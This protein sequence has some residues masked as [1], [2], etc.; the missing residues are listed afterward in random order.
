MEARKMSDKEIYDLISKTLDENKDDL[1]GFLQNLVR[2]NSVT[3]G[4]EDRYEKISD[5]VKTEME[6][7]GLRVICKE[8]NVIGEYGPPDATPVFIF[9]GH[10]DTVELGDDWTVSKPLSGEIINNRIYGRGA[11]DNKSGIAHSMYAVKILKELEEN[12]KIKLNGKIMATATNEE[13]LGGAPVEWL[14][15][16]KII[17]ASAENACILGDGLSYNQVI[18]PCGIVNGC[19]YG[20]ISVTGRSCHADW[21]QYGDNAI[22]AMNKIINLLHK[23]Q[24]EKYNKIKTKYLAH[25]GDDRDHPYINIG[26]IEGGLRFNIVPSDCYAMITI[27]TIPEQNI[28]QV[29][30]EIEGEIMN[31]AKKENLSV[32]F[33]IFEIKMPVIYDEKTYEKLISSVNRATGYMYG[34]VKDI[35]RMAGASDINHFV[36]AGIPSILMGA[37]SP[38]DFIHGANES[39]SIESLLIGT[40]LFAITAFNF[41]KHG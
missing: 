8:K 17:P 14:I 21:P 1:V 33:D 39:V 27:N 30:K 11:A 19:I 12:K 24:E 41:L 28:E 36:N 23:I 3:P 6:K 25:P 4:P 31:L 5:Y 16:E 40:K 7:I 10:M 15:K 22:F 18:H 37:Q 2:F 13:E 32:K 35:R 29:A 9:N 26:Q 34:E 38:A 20:L